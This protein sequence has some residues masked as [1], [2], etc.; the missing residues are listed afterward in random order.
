MGVRSVRPSAWGRQLGCALFCVSPSL[1][2]ALQQ[3]ISSRRKLAGHVMQ[4]ELPRASLCDH[5]EIHVIGPGRS[6]RAERLANQAFHTVSRH[7]VADTTG[8]GETKPRWTSIPTHVDDEHEMAGVQPPASLLTATKIC[9]GAHASKRG[10][11]LPLI[12]RFRALVHDRSDYFLYADTARRQRP[13]RRRFFRTFWPP[14]VSRRLR[15]PWVRSR[16]MLCG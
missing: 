4:C 2:D 12:P 13:L 1:S 9:G 5:D 8:D 3:R 15:K 7:R 14:L 11:A 10:K 6:A 16:L